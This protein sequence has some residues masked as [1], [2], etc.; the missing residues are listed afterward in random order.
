MKKR[1][2]F[3]SNSSSSSFILNVSKEVKKPNDLEECFKPFKYS[4]F[5]CKGDC[6]LKPKSLAKYAYDNLVKINFN[7]YNHLQLFF[8][9]ELNDEIFEKKCIDALI[10]KKE[11]NEEEYKIKKKL[12]EENIDKYYKLSDEI[13]DKSDEEIEKEMSKCYSI[14]EKLR[15]EFFNDFYEKIEKES[16]KQLKNKIK[17]LKEKYDY[18]YIFQAE[19]S[20]NGWISP[21]SNGIYETS[22]KL[23]FQKN[24]LIG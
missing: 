3:V 16:V 14:N 6:I 18:L 15:E 5:E 20:G 4:Y 19:G 12:Y 7:N 8:Y 24:K 17:Q 13:N 22:N 10:E 11:I 2:G 9:K 23:V 21:E 1:S